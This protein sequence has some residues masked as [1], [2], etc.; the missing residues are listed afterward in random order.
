MT[1]AT[2]R[3]KRT[4]TGKMVGYMV[5]GSGGPMWLTKY[6]GEM[7]LMFGNRAT[8]FETRAEATAA[9]RRSDEFSKANGLQWHEWGEHRITPIYAA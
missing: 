2:K 8:M 1:T 3:V 6:K 7:V 5:V 9:I 4:A